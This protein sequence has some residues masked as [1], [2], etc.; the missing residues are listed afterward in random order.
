M[1]IGALALAVVGAIA[2]VATRRSDWHLTP[3][4]PPARVAETPAA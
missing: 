2:I 3:A 1:L 4:P